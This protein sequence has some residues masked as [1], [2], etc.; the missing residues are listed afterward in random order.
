M[1]QLFHPTVSLYLIVFIWVESKPGDK[2]WQ[3]ECCSVLPR[4]GFQKPLLPAASKHPHWNMRK[5]SVYYVYG[6]VCCFNHDSST[7][8]TASVSLPS[9]LVRAA[10]Q[11][12]VEIKGRN[13]YKEHLLQFVFIFPSISEPKTG[14]QI[15]PS[16]C[17]STSPD[18]KSCHKLSQYTWELQRTSPLVASGSC[19]N[20]ANK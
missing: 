11:E 1:L 19:C 20:G 9:F 4:H 3:I 13:A 16:S 5:V 6:T 14:Q 7:S 18:S 12:F 15:A 17:F 10:H 2:Y 8:D